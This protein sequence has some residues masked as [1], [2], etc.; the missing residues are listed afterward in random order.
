MSRVSEL[1]RAS[2]TVGIVGVL[3]ASPLLAILLMQ[4]SYR[5]GPL[6]FS[7][8][9]IFL[10]AAGL[11]PLVYILLAPLRQRARAAGMIA[12]VLTFF[13]FSVWAAQQVNFV[14]GRGPWPAAIFP[15]VSAFAL[16]GW[17]P[18]AGGYCA[19]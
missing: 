13:A 3:T 8:L 9:I 18:I 6:S 4:G 12:G 1:A 10:L 19:G 11:F 16:M 7:P 5:I 17:L 2:V 15:F 14:T